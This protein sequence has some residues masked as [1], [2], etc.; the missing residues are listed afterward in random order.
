MFRKHYMILDA[1]LRAHNGSS[2]GFM[3]RSA[4][5]CR[6]C[7]KLGTVCVCMLAA[8]SKLCVVTVVIIR[9]ASFRCCCGVAKSSVLKS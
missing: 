2:R 6:G 8:Q 3:I 5:S 1:C 9:T 7:C 4:A